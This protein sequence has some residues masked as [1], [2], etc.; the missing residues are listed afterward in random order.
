[1]LNEPSD[2]FDITEEHG[3]ERSAV[4]LTASWAPHTLELATW[5]P[6]AAHSSSGQPRTC[7]PSEACA[8]GSG[9]RVRGGGAETGQEEPKTR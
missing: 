8:R 2:F 1:M 3:H 9:V 7:Y 4:L 6:D 5:A